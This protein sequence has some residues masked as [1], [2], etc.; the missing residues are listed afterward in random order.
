MDEELEERDE[1]DELDELEDELLLEELLLEEL[2]DEE[3]LEGCDVDCWVLQPCK[4][5]SEVASSAATGTAISL[6]IITLLCRP[7]S[8]TP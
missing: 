6:F 1:L 2:L 4:V 8:R 5:R 3:G 7:S